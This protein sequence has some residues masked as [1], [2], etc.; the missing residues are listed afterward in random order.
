M[1]TIV[2]PLLPKQLEFVQCN[3]S[4]V[5]YSGAFG[6][7]KT[8]ATCEKVLTHA[9]LPLNRVGLCRKTLVSLKATTLKTLLDGDG[10]QPPVLP[11]GSYTHNKSDKSIQV[12]GGGEIVYF[13]LDQPEKIGSLNLGACGV[14]EAV[15][16]EEDDWVMLRG[17]CR[18]QVDPH[19]QLFGACNPGPPTHFL[20]D[21]FGLAGGN[22]P[23]PGCRAIET[24]SGDNFFLPVDYVEWL[25]T[26]TG[27]HAAR[28]R[29]GKWVGFEGLVY[30]MWD[31]AVHIK[32]RPGP[33]A[34]IW[35]A[36]DEGYTNPAVLLSIGEDSDGRMHVFDAFYERQVL[37]SEFVNVVKTRHD[38]NGIQE[39]V[40]DP[41]AVG[42]VRDLQAIDLIVI[43]DLDNA[44]FDGIKR[45]QD[46]LA[47]QGDG[48]PR[49]TVDPSCVDVIREFES[50]LWKTGKDEPVKTLD[51]AM[52]AIRYLIAYVDSWLGGS[53]IQTGSKK[54]EMA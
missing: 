37:P 10:D 42:L 53:G 23:A 18:N 21:R 47:V 15:E 43:T 31:R 39:M 5:L 4:E 22:R 41:S 13:G 9:V 24:R 20:A 49:L 19:R 40:A 45:V 51:H 52:D 1:T 2:R 28:Y 30:D 3:D 38:D 35:G 27:T 54:R 7:G 44:V 8:R 12:T 32:E 25:N 16:L 34:R 14:D 33:W 48:R 36:I 6:A 29:D 50:Y 17:R 11:A 26:L 46:R